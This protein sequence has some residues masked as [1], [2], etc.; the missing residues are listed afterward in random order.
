[1]KH[2]TSLLWMIGVPAAVI[3][4]TAVIIWMEPEHKGITRAAVCKAAAL[5]VIS[6][7]ECAAEAEEN[8]SYFSA[9]DRDQ[10]YVKY[11]DCLYRRGILSEETMPADSGTA[12]GNLTFEEADQ[13]ITG[14]LRFLSEEA[15]G[16]NPEREEM[17]K[18]SRRVRDQIKA[19]K[20]NA[21]RPFPE[22]RW[23]QIYG[24]ICAALT[25]M[26]GQS[27]GEE[28]PLITEKVLQIYGTPDNL[29]EAAPWTA[30]TNDGVYG[31]E[32]LGLDRYIDMEIKVLARE[33]EIITVSELVSQDITC[34][35]LWIA[36]VGEDEITCYAGEIV[37]TFPVDLK[38]KNAE[39]LTNQLADVRL[40]GGKVE[41]ITLKKER[42]TARALAVREDAIELE[43]YGEV[44]LDD[45][46]AVYKTYGQFERADLSQILVGYDTQEFIAAEGKLCAA[47]I[48]R[49]FDAETIR[50][51]LMDSGFRSVF[52]DRVELEFLSDGFMVQGEEETVFHKGE[53]V[54]LEP[55][56]SR[57]KKGRLIFRP[58][59][60][61]A[62]IRFLSLDR[63]GGKQPDYPGKLEI[64]QADEGLVAINDLYLEDYL[65][66][67]LPSEMPV[68]YEK[69][70]LK[71]QAV[72]ARTYAYRQIQSNSYMEYGAHV[73]DS[74][75]F[76]VY[77]NGGSGNAADEAVDETYGEF[78][79]YG[80]DVADVYYFSTSCGH[81]ADVTAWGEDLAKAPYLSAKA[82]R[83][84]G[85]RLDLTTNDAFG[86]FI[87]S[88]PEGF[89]S[90][91]GMYRW[92]VTVTGKQ[93]EE[94]M[95][96]LGA[97]TK[98][99]MAERGEG[100]IG[101]VL[102]IEGIEGTREI[103]GEGQIRSTLAVPD[104]E[105]RRQDGKVLTGWTSLPSAFIAIDQCQ[106]EEGQGTAF[107]IYGGGYGHG[108]GMSQNGAQAMAERG[109]KY[110]E[111][112]GFFYEGTNLHT[113]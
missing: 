63:D 90:D 10:W 5:A 6:P 64:I 52:H 60:E 34:R 109:W 40:S 49:T 85:G 3:L 41:K 98:I 69:E 44:E 104:M 32:G 68:S 96:E 58:S 75:R 83:N 55:G 80:D 78:L 27:G 113:W 35:N 16:D 54:I 2:R 91:Y 67:V 45:N 108:I 19:N 86:E 79:M 13:V 33:R 39:E 70:A 47:L 102:V 53:T 22:N 56:D 111:I 84:G 89:E 107:K 100:G 7:D 9:A 29:P 82:V 4:L 71:A 24:D 12:E 43:G 65:K 74:T 103:R 93:L 110:D 1:M 95:P 99:A 17:E 30:Y 59:D 28:Q 18:L 72:C 42:I 101:K 36:G 50:V 81:T 48:V 73:D 11:A 106:P 21:D 105:I 20:R 26:S 46:F 112:L 61:N 37:R 92:T 62:G 87:K 15:G 23:R 38:I 14:L 77:N 66:R 8:E 94:K 57:M 51:L 31:F 76:Q 97:I 25:V 88:R